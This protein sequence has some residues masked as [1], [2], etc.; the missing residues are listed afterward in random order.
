M[1]T[2]MGADAFHKTTCCEVINM[3]GTSVTDTACCHSGKKKGYSESSLE[4]CWE[5]RGLINYKEHS[6]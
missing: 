1:L 3:D 6:D 5:F 2:F 4:V